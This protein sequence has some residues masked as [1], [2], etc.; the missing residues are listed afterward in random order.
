MSP[1]R[2][3]D[4]ELVDIITRQWENTVERRTYV[5]G[6]MGSHHLDEAFGADFELP[7]DRAYSETCAGIASAMLSW[8]L[9]LESGDRRYADL[10]ERTLLN[11]VLA[12]P[13]EDGRAFYY[14]N[15]LHQRENGSEPAD[16]EVIDRALSSLRAPW[17]WVSCCPTNVARTLASV[18]L[19]FAT[20]DDD[21]VQLQQYG[22]YAIS[23]ALARRAL[24][25]A[26][27][28][29][30]LSLRWRRRR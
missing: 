22:D 19:Y 7:A 23:T 29:L 5:T 4:A 16:D 25:R 20:A 3:A 24:G 13:R 28:R 21:G 17:F 30:G 6:G 2:P 12:S 1:S 26:L 15:T 14:T 9:L 11:N 27:R 10:I 18:D 8:R